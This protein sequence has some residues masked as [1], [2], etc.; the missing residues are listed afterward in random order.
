[1][2]NIEDIINYTSTIKLLYVEDNEEARTSTLTILE[3]FFNDIVVAVDGKD[4]LEKFQQ[5][6]IDLIIT[7]INM[8]KLNGLDM[9]KEIRKIDKEISI[10]VLSAYNESGYFMES[11]KLGVEGY[12]LKPI[13][14][15][16]FMEMLQKVTKIFKLKDEAERN[17]IF[18]HQYQEATDKSSIVSKTDL[19]GKITYV[20]DE[21]CKL[22]KYSRDELIGKNHNIVR[23]PD[24]SS[25][26]FKE[27]WD[28]IKNKKSI[29]QG[30]V[31]NLAKDGSS[32][33]V[34]AT[35]KPILDQNEE[36]VEYISLRE[37]IT[38]IM[39]PKIQL[40]DLVNS[41]EETIVVLLKIERFDD[42]EKFYGSTLSQKIEEN[43]SKEILKLIPKKCEFTKVFVLDN[44][45]YAFAKNKQE[46]KISRDKI[47]QNLK[48]VQQVVND[49]K[50]DIGEV[51]YDISVLISF[52]DGKNTLENAKY[53]LKQ[54]LETKQDFIVAN[55][56]IAREHDEA[57]KNL[58]VLKMIKGA[59]DDSKII[60]Y[61]QPIIN[62]QT[63][64]IEK[65]ESLVRLVDKEDKV[66]SPFFFL[67]TAKKAKYYSQITAIVLENSF[68]ALNET[69]KEISINISVLDI[70]K[71]L[72]RE[73]IFEFLEV[74]SQN[75][76]RVVFELLE[77]ESVKDFKLIKSFIS[78]VKKMG[79][80]IAVDD[81][82][83]GYSNFERLLDYQPDILKIDGCLIKNIDHDE[84][85]LNVV[86][87]IVAFAKKQK[88]KTV[89]E[90]VENEKIFNILNNL[91]V[92]YSQ[93]YYFGKP[94]VLR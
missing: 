91:G 30:M 68:N 56:L 71:H 9:I 69:D 31:R 18:L 78:D 77:D 2:L 25:S 20:N 15:E 85:S 92:D 76:H 22:S 47:I 55:N 67:E 5:Q 65:Y 84:F 3:E 40:Q 7:D 23:H 14:I 24:M 6:K 35:I 72:T 58:E 88:I 39:S 8:P 16:Q 43:F 94:E 60:S 83:A 49:A 79:V 70:E 17:L 12:L 29:W 93:G 51:D 64:Q 87:T 11:I 52:A 89:A 80:K 63:K 81:F 57:K 74:N 21:F 32:Y 27:M 42:I 37:D 33:Y 46:C 38:D 44:G 62:N 41:Y 26:A 4:G 86:E 10:L 75:L 45:E 53:G 61:F 50:L 28:T 90:F 48:E 1:M 66:L 54:L 59:I 82:G 19:K 73:K 13:D 36:V 34:K